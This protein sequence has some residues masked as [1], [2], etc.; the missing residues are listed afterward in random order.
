MERRLNLLWIVPIQFVV[1]LYLVVSLLGPSGLVGLVMT[2]LLTP[3]TRR[4]IGKL[5]VLQTDARK[6]T[7]ERVRYVLECMS[8]IRI[9]KVRQADCLVFLV[10]E[11]RFDL[12]LNAFTI[13]PIRC[14]S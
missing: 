6:E 13:G 10:R 4:F 11:A 8:G 2:L 3:I 1:S 9:L 7:D 5:H 12:P 14:S